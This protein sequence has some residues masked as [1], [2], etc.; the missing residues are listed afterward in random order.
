MR[1]AE[2]LGIVGYQMG[3]NFALAGRLHRKGYN[4]PL[5]A[6]SG[7][8]TQRCLF[9]LALSL[10]VRV[11]R[12]GRVVQV[13]AQLA[14]VIKRVTEAVFHLGFLAVWTGEV[15]VPH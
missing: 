4:L 10:A 13:D 14:I 15:V 9:V 5:R 11:I 2:R 1:C 7:E 12:E 3:E 8:H 6:Q